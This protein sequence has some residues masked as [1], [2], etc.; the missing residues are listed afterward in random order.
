[1]L[2]THDVVYVDGALKSS[3][4]HLLRLVQIIDGVEDLVSLPVDRERIVAHA[5]LPAP[6]RRLVQCVAALVVS[7]VTTAREID[8]IACR[9][10]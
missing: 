4:R 3:C 8:G 1:M 7:V 10:Q 6:V 2:G 9:N 5:D